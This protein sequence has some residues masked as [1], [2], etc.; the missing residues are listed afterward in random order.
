MKIIYKN[1][2]Y[3][4]VWSVQAMLLFEKIMGYAFRGKTVKDNIVMLYVILVTIEGSD[5]N[6]NYHEYSSW[7]NQN[8]RTLQKFINWTEEQEQ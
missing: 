3:D 5:K 8:A 7:I 4:L 1:K 2:E 6:L